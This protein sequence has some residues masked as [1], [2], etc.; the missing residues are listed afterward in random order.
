MVDV[1]S[2]SRCDPMV[3]YGCIIGNLTTAS[4][5]FEHRLLREGRQ[6][7]LVPCITR[8]A[9]QHT[10]KKNCS[11][12]L[13]SVPAHIIAQIVHPEIRTTK[14]GK[15]LRGTSLLF[16]F[17]LGF[18]HEFFIHKPTGGMHLAHKELHR[19]QVLA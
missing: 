6:Y 1:G 7:M 8:P 15:L 18:L 19:R 10:S 16:Y 14:S 5:T 11:A 13:A 4:L 9:A 12:H 17:R 2:A 3:A